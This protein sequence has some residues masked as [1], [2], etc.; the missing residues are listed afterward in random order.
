MGPKTF[1][2]LAILLTC[3][4][5]AA[6]SIV[7]GQ[8]TQVERMD[9]KL[10]AL[11]AQAEKEGRLDEAEKL[12]QEH[13]EIAPD[14]LQAKLAYASLLLKGRK[15]QSRWAKA[16]DF[17]GQQVTRYPDD[18]TNL[19][20]LAKLEVE[21]NRY[22]LA[23]PRLE[24]LLKSTNS[25]VGSP[26]TAEVWFLL[27]RCQE[28]S[29]D[30]SRAKE[31]YRQA[32]QRGAP[33]SIKASARLADLV[34][35]RLEKADQS[36]DKSRKKGSRCDH[37]GD[38]E[39]GPKQ[40]RGLPRRGR[41][42]RLFGQTPQDQE[43]AR[44]DLHLALEK[45][46]SD[47]K[48]YEELV[49]L[50]QSA[51]N[52]EEANRVIEKGLDTLPE[53]DTPPLRV[54]LAMLKWIS[55][56]GTIDKAIA[57]L[58]ESIQTVPDQAYLRL[59]L[60]NL[61]AQRGE[62]DELSK[63]IEELKR[64]NVWPVLTGLLEARVEINR[65]KD[66][67]KAIQLLVRLVT[68]VEPY[69]EL[70]GQVHYF[71]A[72]CY[73][74]LDD[75]E[76]EREQYG[77]SVRANPKN[78]E[79]R[80]GLAASMARRGEIENAINE[81]RQLLS[82]LQP[83]QRD[84]TFTAV[85]GSLIQLLIRRELPKPVDRRDWSEVNKLVELVKASAPQSDES[86]SLETEAL[87]AQNKTAE[88]QVLLD[89]ARARTPSDLNAW[90]RSVDILLGQQKPN[91]ALKLL[92]QAQ[93]VLGDGVALRLKRAQVAVYQ[94]ASDSSKVLAALAENIGAFSPADQ[95]RLLRYLAGSA[96]VLSDR[97]LAADLWMR[98]AK[99][100]PA[101][102]EPRLNLLEMA[103]QGKDRA[104]IEH[105]L[106][107]I[108][109]VEGDN[110]A[111][112]K[113]GQA[114][115][116]V[117]QAANSTDL[118]E[119]TTLRAAAETLFTKLI[120]TQKFMNSPQ[121]HLMLADLI[122]AD[123]SQPELSQNDKK[124][125][126]NEAASYYLKAVTLG[127]KDQN[128]VGRA[129]DL[130]YKADNK[131]ELAQLRNLLLQASIE[132][133]PT[134]AEVAVRN[135]D[136]LGA[137]Q[138]AQAAKNA[139]PNEFQ[140]AYFLARMLVI[141]GQLAEA[142]SVL[143][144]AVNAVPADP[145]RRVVLVT[146]LTDTR[147]LEKAE[148]A[149]QD[150]EKTLTDKPLSN[151]SCCELL[152]VAYK[153][154]ALDE[155]K[156]KRWFDQADRWYANARNDQPK[157][158]DVSQKR[159]VSRRY[160]RFLA[161]IGQVRKARGVLEFLCSANIAQPQD[162]FQ[163]AVLSSY[164]GDWAKAHS[165]YFELLAETKN[166]ND[167]T[168]LV[169]RAE[170]IRQF[171]NDL[172]KHYDSEPDGN[173]L[174]E[175]QAQIAELRKLGADAFVV[176]G[177]DARLLK[178]RKQAGKAIELVQE[179]ASRPSLTEYDWLRLVN[180]AEQLGQANLARDLL[181]QALEKT[182]SPQV[183]KVLASVR[184]Q[185]GRYQEAEDLY[186]QYIEKAPDDAVAL[187][188]LAWLMALQK[189]GEPMAL[190]HINRA[191]KVDETNSEFLDTRGVIYIKLRKVQ[192]AISDLVTATKLAATDARFFHLAQAYLQSGDK[193]SARQALQKAQRRG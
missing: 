177:L 24:V 165:Q 60:A 124:K 81:Y 182:N 33:Q 39:L 117:W 83:Q 185:E 32:I 91:D 156:S 168:A 38:G 11:A 121:I 40:L 186:S 153:R 36:A 94:K 152:G 7:F 67:K 1:K 149:V 71:M 167:A 137:L 10:L 62:T 130:L 189:H 12:Y 164:D 139:H 131:E 41:Y 191:I 145:E 190:E 35:G 77:L 34:L 172:L 37:Q 53:Q 104:D 45:N 176:M 84:R 4:L 119:Q 125:K 3:V 22:S 55:P 21:L 75:R 128:T 2:R 72:Q 171:A 106:D 179:F 51:K 174:D 170:Y 18:T 144:E 183:L 20:R 92:D 147:Q 70:N 129:T 133:L 79:A 6:V 142:E 154:Y 63:Q 150:A 188:N 155:Q 181:R 43:N 143:R 29:G 78:F 107:D 123:L 134:A 135:K 120:Q 169:R 61:L 19:L 96:A 141:N 126:V 74:Q 23:R 68:Q 116:L 46:R 5:V 99:L 113:F 115:Y 90:L 161:S 127:Q 17:Y 105:W 66:W 28:E 80:L 98:I 132:L 44:K 25:G 8:R 178:A 86:L 151:A 47:P 93:K 95:R 163:L 103:L 26:N 158:A 108:K 157:N 82:Q 111:S 65:K 56:S 16:A 58:R 148:T 42:L 49:E 88:A 140:V 102:L 30:Y 73:G 160:A 122:L 57:S 138:L 87:I 112:L 9:R 76:R 52:Y 180:L 114:Q 97:S 85:C 14:D 50:E 166:S 48:I 193:P 110:G 64:L 187:N 54:K 13:L 136:K 31:A 15:D 184:D 175:A 59:T 118:R 173:L 27:G 89:K 101:S 69:P 109:Q 100:D 192:D 146:F 162:K 159:D